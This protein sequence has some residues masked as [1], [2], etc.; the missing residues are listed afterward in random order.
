MTA[1]TATPVLPLLNGFARV[2][3]LA[4]LAWLWVLGSRARQ[5]SGEWFGG[6][7]VVAGQCD[8][9]DAAARLAELWAWSGAPLLLLLA[10]VLVTALSLPSRRRVGRADA[11]LAAYIG[12][13][14]VLAPG[15]L[16]AVVV[17]SIGSHSP[18]AAMVSLLTVGVLLAGVFELLGRRAGVLGG[19]PR[20]AHLAGWALVAAAGGSGLIVVRVGP[21]AALL[22][23]AVVAAAV[24]AVIVLT[25]APGRALA[26]GL[27]LTCWVALVA[28]GAWGVVTG[29][30]TERAK[31]LE[32]PASSSP[33]P[34]PDAPARP[35]PS[36][37]PSATVDPAG[38]VAS[39]PAWWRRGPAPTRTCRSAWRAGTRPWASPR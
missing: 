20:G 28:G 26:T 23:S 1:P 35:A 4:S 2:T 14:V 5:W 16:I 38:V 19:S 12:A 11:R 30:R 34:P 39:R 25:D 36:T 24:A 18:L 22:L 31:A 3:T 8:T 6:G 37:T 9:P 13:A 17:L 33:T 32:R 27:A 10:S 29:V 7:C 21:L 15:G